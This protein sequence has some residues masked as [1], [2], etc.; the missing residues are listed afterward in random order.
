MT[1]SPEAEVP[2]GCRRR[3]RHSQP[4][5]SRTSLLRSCN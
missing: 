5:R 3:I 2:L 4:R 1:R